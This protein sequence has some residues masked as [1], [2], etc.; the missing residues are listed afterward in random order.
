[1]SHMGFSLFCLISKTPKSV[2]S[3]VITGKEVNPPYTLL[4]LHKKQD[5]YG[6]RKQ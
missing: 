3:G 5:N 6:R 4:Y 1:M 2:K